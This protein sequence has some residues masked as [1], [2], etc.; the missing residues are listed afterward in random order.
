[1]DLQYRRFDGSFVAIINEMPY[2]ITL[3]DERYAVAKDKADALGNALPFE[4]APPMPEPVVMTKI[5]K[6]DIWR[7]ATDAE[8]VTIKTGLLQQPVRLQEL[9][10]S[11]SYISTTDELYT[12]LRAGF[13]AVFG[14]ARTNDLLEATE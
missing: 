11:V 10:Q 7:R 5:Y 12:A 9:W 8:A 3:D 13:V 2:H 6:S 4:P 1:M 14:E